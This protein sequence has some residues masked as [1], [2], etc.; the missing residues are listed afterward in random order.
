MGSSREVTGRHKDGSAVSVELSVSEYNINGERLFVGTLR[1]I[2][3]RQAL[4]ASLTQALAAA[5]QGSRAT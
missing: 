5:E 4:I 2:R 3:G 1:D